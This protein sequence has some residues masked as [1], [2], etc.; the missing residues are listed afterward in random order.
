M[1]HRERVQEAKHFIVRKTST[2]RDHRFFTFAFAC[3]LYNV[4]RLVDLLVKLALDGEYRSYAPLVDA[5]QFLTVAKQ[6]YG[7]DPPD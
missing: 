1:G 5:N 3:V 6:W 7:L 2:E 4:W